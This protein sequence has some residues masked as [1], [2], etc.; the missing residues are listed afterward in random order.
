YGITSG[1]LLAAG[2][3]SVALASEE[4]GSTPAVAGDARLQQE[5][6]QAAQEFDVPQSV[7]MAV[8]YQSSLWDTHDGRP[9]TTGS[10]NV[11]GLTHVTASEVDPSSDQQQLDHLNMSGDPAV[12]KHFDAKRALKSAKA[13]VNT[14]DPRLHTLDEG[15]KL[16]GTSVSTVQ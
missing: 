3:G 5:F 12:M 7:L 15:A 11:M 2:L 13:A 10:Y 1:V 6:A 8:A 14:A 16:I 4:S 9:S